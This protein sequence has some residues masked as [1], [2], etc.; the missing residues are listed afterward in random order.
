MPVHVLAGMF[1]LCGGALVFELA[2]NK[3]VGVQ[4]YGRLGDIA[5]GTALFGYALAGVLF[6]TSERLRRIPSDVIAPWACL[7]TGLAMPAAHLTTTWVPLAFTKFFTDP[8]QTLGATAIWYLA[9]ALPFFTSSLAIVSLLSGASASGRR[10]GRLYG[11]DLVGAGCGAIFG[12]K[13]IALLGGA[14]IL[15]FAGFLC[16]LGGVFF[17]YR[18]SRRL[19]LG[20][21][22]A[23]IAIGVGS[24]L[25]AERIGIRVHEPKREFLRDEAEGRIERTAWSAVSRVDFAKHR[26]MYMI[27]FDGGSQQSR[28]LPPESALTEVQLEGFKASSTT[29]AYRLRPR[30]NVMVLASSGGN[31]VRGA[32]HFGAEHVTAVEIDPSVCKLLKTTYDGWLEGLFTGT[33]VTLINSEGR[34]YV[35]HSPEKYDVIQIESAYSD[36]ML[37]TGAAGAY[38]TFLLTTEAIKEYWNHLTD[39]GVLWLGQAHSVRLFTQVLD[40]LDSLG[41]DPEGR[42]YYERGHLSLGGYVL[43]LR[44]TPFP[45]EELDVLE[46]HVR[47]SDITFH[48]APKGLWDR[49]GS[50]WKGMEPDPNLRAV[51]NKIYARSGEERTAFLETLPYDALPSTDDMPF[52]NRYFG[53]LARFPVTGAKDGLPREIRKMADAGRTYGP[54]PISDVPPVVILLEAALLMLPVIFLPWATLRRRRKLAG[55][56]RPRGLW[57][58]CIYFVCVGLGFIAV[59]VV[60]ARRYVLFFGSPTVALAVVLGGLLTFA[61]LGSA[62]LSPLVSGRRHGAAGVIF[63]LVA[64]LVFY[65]YGLDSLFAPLQGSSAMVRYAAGVVIL[66]P[67]GLLMGLPFPSGLRQVT[68]FGEGRVAW[69]WALNGYAS[70]VATASI[71]IGIQI[72]G[73]RML[74][75]ISAATYLIA[76]LCSLGMARRSVTRS[77]AAPVAELAAGSGS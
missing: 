35:S 57:F 2:F 45:A 16:A 75:F 69:A 71:G 37:F 67:L 43:V 23:A 47:Q 56:Q 4:G 76:G 5:I 50:K 49:L 44:K 32:L 53:F 11:S 68:R 73:Y 66:L 13:G 6:V 40:A 1:L 31:Q 65:A 48:F 3:I 61:G 9:L 63:A 46:Q 12:I 54:V 19:A 26:D 74:F 70:V 20:I 51:V 72:F 25:V 10:V 15:W 58:E 39:D 34:S 8:L 14:G 64:L 41:V 59:E 30:K 29:L 52:Y 24:F 62:L 33:K 27:W 7:A 42:I 17:A 55:E 22:G 60:L 36:A 21:L 28:M 38:N 18:T 77:D